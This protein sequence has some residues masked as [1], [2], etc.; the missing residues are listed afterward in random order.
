MLEEPYTGLRQKS[1]LIHIC[2]FFKRTFIYININ[3]HFFRFKHRNRFHYVT[4]EE[5]DHL[6]VRND[7]VDRYNVVQL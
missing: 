1:L 6:Y 2:F 7:V 5:L 3:L 4:G